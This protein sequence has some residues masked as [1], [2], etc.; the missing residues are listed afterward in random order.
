MGNA[1]E[2]TREEAL[3]ML[4]QPAPNAEIALKQLLGVVIVPALLKSADKGRVGAKGTGTDG[5]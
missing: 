1:A 5:G 2:D 4:P 3:G